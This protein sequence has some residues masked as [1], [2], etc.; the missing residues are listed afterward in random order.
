MPSA[1]LILVVEDDR[2]IRVL[3]GQFLEGKGYRLALANEFSVGVQILDA[4]KPILLIADILLRGG[5]GNELAKLALARGVPVLLISGHPA[6]IE[7]NRGRAIPFLEKPFRL[8][9]LEQKID[10]LLAMA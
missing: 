5:N 7:D 1:P 9:E 2:D 8:V 10:Q 3:L 4:T 6:E